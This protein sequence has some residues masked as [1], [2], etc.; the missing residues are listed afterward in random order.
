MALAPAEGNRQY[1]HYGLVLFWILDCSLAMICCVYSHWLQLA[2]LH[3]VIGTLV[4]SQHL[5]TMK[6]LYKFVIF[7]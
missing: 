5:P 7:T 2:T 4:L 6:E 1:F 3:K